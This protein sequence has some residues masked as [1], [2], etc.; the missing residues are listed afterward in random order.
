MSTRTQIGWLLGL[1]LAAEALLATPTAQAQ[2]IQITGPL[3]GAPAV[4]RMRIYREERFQ[5][6]PGVSFSLQDEFS[7]AVFV[8]AEANYH[9]TD[10]IGVGVAGAYGVAQINTDLTTQVQENGVVVDRNRLSLPS[11]EGFDDQIGRWNWWLALQVTFIPLRGKLALFQNFFLDTDFFISAGF[12][13]AG[14]E[15]RAD[16]TSGVCSPENSGGIT[17]PDCLATQSARASSIRPTGTFAVGL[18]VYANDWFGLSFEYRAMPFAW[19]TSGF[20]N[21][22]D[23]G[24]TNNPDEIIDSNDRV[25]QFNQMFTLGLSF[26][27]PTEAKT[28]R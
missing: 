20:D 15:E 2:E 9:F 12:A 22:D 1:V 17:S 11:N 19:N 5:L 3:A 21:K 16:V 25:F 6:K 14:I 23:Q 10:W 28:S 26:Y 4:R 13:L 24:E 18:T 7:R 8:G 27:L